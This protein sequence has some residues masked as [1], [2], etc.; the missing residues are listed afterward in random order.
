[1]NNKPFV[2]GIAGGSGSGKTFFL[3]CFLHHFTPDQISL[4]SQDDYYKPMSEQPKDA[5]G[6]INFDLPECIDDQRLLT[7]L[8]VLLSGETVFK[9]EYTF[10]TAEESAKMLTINSAPIIIVEGLFIFH[11]QEISSLFDMKIF[12]DA[13]EEITLN[14]RLKR[15]IAER[16]YDHSM[17]MYQWVN[18]VLP[19]YNAYLLPYKN[20][21]DK[22]IL[23]NTHV[24]DDI[25]E[26]TKCLAE[27]LK[28]NVLLD[29]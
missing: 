28:A 17:I 7:D 29:Y 3:N 2:I 19:A 4:V 12:M 20:S 23:N 22:I 24:A 8:S 9:K 16:G 26:V 25:I 5:N 21:A 13:N 15:D 18:H 11:F 1:M 6:W 27:E 14:R 10:N